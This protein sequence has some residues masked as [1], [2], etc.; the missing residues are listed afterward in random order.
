MCLSVLAFLCALFLKLNSSSV[1][2]VGE[3]LGVEDGVA[4]LDIVDRVECVHRGDRDNR[5]QNWNPDGSLLTSDHT[6]VSSHSGCSS[7][8]ICGSLRS[9]LFGGIRYKFVW[10]Q[11]Q[12][13]K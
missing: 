8:I 2:E 6:C 13:S 1:L 10:S 4:V 11:K 3:E 12:V 5:E 7:D 9:G